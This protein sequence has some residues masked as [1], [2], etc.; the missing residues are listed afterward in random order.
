M[1]YIS[2]EIKNNSKFSHLSIESISSS[3]ST[4]KTPDQ[5][6]QIIEKFAGNEIDIILSTDVLSEG[7]NLQ[8]AKYLINYDLHWNP[9]RMIQ[10]A[11]R[12]DRI[13]SPFKEI[14]IYN[15]FPEDELEELLKLVRILQEKIINFDTSIGLD[16]SVLG[17][18]IHPKVFGAIKKIKNKDESVLVDLENDVFG[19]G[20]KFYQPLKDFLKNSAIEELEKIPYGV[21][22]GLKDKPVSGVFFYYKYGNDFNFWYVH[23]IKTTKLISNR[24]EIIDYIFC[25][26]EEKRV[27]P[28]FFDSIYDI[29]QKIIDKI[30][31]DYQEIYASKKQDTQLK[32]FDKS[33]AT[34]FIRDMLQEIELQIDSYIEDY[35]EDKE[36]VKIW[37]STRDKLLKIAPT[38][39][40]LQS[41]RKM[42]RDYKQNKDWKLLIRKLEEFSVDKGLIQTETI[43]EFDIV[44]LKLI[45]VDFI[46]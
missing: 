26:P 15:F 30:I 44:K 13:G 3:G 33:G 2:K 39:K 19:G 31:A 4:C 21:F 35:P 36:I 25:P 7:Q 27:I 18:E 40:R 9:T 6:A 45:T 10:R 11:G 46:S 24:S 42:W 8:N 16:Q 41:L 5:R 12:I 29:N 28:E 43:E 1:N 22:S 34:K 17:E 23:D 20:E 38:K 32:G 37:D 14:F